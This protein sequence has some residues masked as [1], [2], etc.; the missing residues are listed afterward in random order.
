MRPPR[1]SEAREQDTRGVGLS[2][3]GDLQAGV[4]GHKGQK[5]VQQEHPPCCRGEWDAILQVPAVLRPEIGR[6][7][8]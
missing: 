6:A 5:D 1:H 7:H 3:T 4:S 8:V 2:R